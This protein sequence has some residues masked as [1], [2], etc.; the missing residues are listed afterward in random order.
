MIT[1]DKGF[2]LNLPKDDYNGPMKRLV[3]TTCNVGVRK[4]S[5]MEERLLVR[6]VC[7]YLHSSET[8]D[9]LF[10]SHVLFSIMTNSPSVI[11]FVSWNIRTPVVILFLLF[12]FFE[13][14]DFLFSLQSI[15][16]QLF[17]IIIHLYY[18]CLSR[19]HSIPESSCFLFSFYIKSIIIIFQVKA[20]TSNL[21]HLNLSVLLRSQQF[22][23]SSF[24]RYSFY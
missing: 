1:L 7:Y 20:L 23:K 15:L 4:T 19:G 13:F 21:F 22:Q 2:G 9:I 5:K 18:S 12:S 8:I 10:F 17:A 24:F 16:Q 6:S 3:S 14:T 11:L